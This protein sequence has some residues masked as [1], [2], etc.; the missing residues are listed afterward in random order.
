MTECCDKDHIQPFGHGPVATTSN[1]ETC[2][3]NVLV[4]P[5]KKKAS[6][7]KKYIEQCFLGIT[8]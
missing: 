1:K 8:W 2:L 4:S 3:L 6:K 5:V 7:L